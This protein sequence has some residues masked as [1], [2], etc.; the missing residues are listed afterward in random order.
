MT[1]NGWNDNDWAFAAVCLGLPA[2][3]VLYLVI[4]ALFG[5]AA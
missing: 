5:G 1:G 2:V 4:R 3:V